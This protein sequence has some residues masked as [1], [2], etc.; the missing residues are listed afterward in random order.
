MKS[1]LLVIFY[2]AVVFP[3]GASAQEE[4]KKIYQVWLARQVIGSGGAYLDLKAAE[5]S[6]SID[7]LS[8]Y[9]ANHLIATDR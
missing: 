5:S 1:R 6:C 4:G 8:T 9:N 7:L 2:L 3:A